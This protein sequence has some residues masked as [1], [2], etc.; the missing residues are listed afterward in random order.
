MT[1]IAPALLI[2][3]LLALPAPAQIAQSLAFDAVSI[4]RTHI[5]TI[6]KTIEF[7]S[8]CHGITMGQHDPKADH[9]SIALRDSIARNLFRGCLNGRRRRSTILQPR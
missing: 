5:A 6:S 7:S 3:T 2:L 4:K 1:K 9:T 8:D